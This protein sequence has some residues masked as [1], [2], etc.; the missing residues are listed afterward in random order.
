MEEKGLDRERGGVVPTTGH[1][2]Q[3]NRATLSLVDVR[4]Y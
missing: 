4:E 2:G 3:R 1:P